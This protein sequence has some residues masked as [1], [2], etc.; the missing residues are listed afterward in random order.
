[1]SNGVAAMIDGLT[2]MARAPRSEWLKIAHEIE[3]AP[4]L[5]TADGG[6]QAVNIASAARILAPTFAHV[7]PENEEEVRGM[8]TALAA[9][10]A[11][12]REARGKQWR[13][14][15]ARGTA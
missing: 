2:R 15:D 12:E 8:A 4:R 5:M 9:M 7:C 13:R 14:H 3:A 10:L 1:M 11:N 6:I